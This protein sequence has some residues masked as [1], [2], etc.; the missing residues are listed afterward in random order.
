MHFHKHKRALM[1]PFGGFP[2]VIPGQSVVC[3]AEE[4]RQNHRR[5]ARRSPRRS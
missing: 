5:A 2:S 3:S 1:A 4:T